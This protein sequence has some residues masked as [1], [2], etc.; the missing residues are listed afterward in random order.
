MYNVVVDEDWVSKDH[1]GQINTLEFQDAIGTVLGNANIREVVRGS[2]LD[3]LALDR[4]EDWREVV[5]AFRVED[6][7]G[8]IPSFGTYLIED[9]CNHIS[10]VHAR[11]MNVTWTCVKDGVKSRAI[12]E[13]WSHLIF[14][15]MDIWLLPWIPNR[16]RI[17]MRWPVKV[18]Q[19]VK[20]ENVILIPY[21][22]ELWL[23]K[24]DEGN[25][26]NWSHIEWKSRFWNDALLSHRKQ[27]ERTHFILRIWAVIERLIPG[28][29]KKPISWL[30]NTL[31]LG[32]QEEFKVKDAGG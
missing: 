5:V 15:S 23:A 2:Q 31:L 4:E 16:D 20:V 8:V 7:L 26:A 27:V 12:L 29:T 19:N 6:S 28:E 18:F 10:K 3:P 13:R 30:E 32:Y 9:L 1:V 14:E 21:I 11:D 24:I 22:L 25:L 17:C